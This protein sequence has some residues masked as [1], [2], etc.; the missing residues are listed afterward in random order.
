[1]TNWQS[2]TEAIK[3]TYTAKGRAASGCYSIEG[4][5][6][7]ERALRAN[8]PLQLVLAA[9]RYQHQPPG[10]VQQL[11]A[12]LRAAN[13]PLHS[14]PDAIMADLTNGRSLGGF[15]GLVKL[16]QP[17]DLTAITQT[18]H[19][20]LLVT[21]DVVDPGNLGAMLRTGHA[22]GITAL[23]AIGGSDPFHPKAARTSMGS[24]FKIPILP[25][26][27]PVSL[28]AHLQKSGIQTVGATAQNGVPLSQAD[29]SGSG[30][31]VFMGSEYFGLPEAIANQLD[32]LVTIP[33]AEGIDSLSINAAT[34]VILY[35]IT[36]AFR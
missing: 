30:T 1:M 16:P 33:M 6:L 18:P 22:F 21:V 2:A 32:S 15:L 35:E 5:R 25:Q 7:H 19:P 20:L 10:R 3:R 24:L 4:I 28:L 8:V 23:I 36:R 9:E 34:A 14:V 17:P 26:A 27:D 11:L 13:I 12:D 29:F 31:A